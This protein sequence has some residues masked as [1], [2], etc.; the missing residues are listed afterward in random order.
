MRGTYSSDYPLKNFF[1]KSQ[2]FFQKP[3]DKHKMLCYTISVDRRDADQLPLKL[4]LKAAGSLADGYPFPSVP[5]GGSVCPFSPLLY[6][7]GL[8]VLPITAMVFIVMS[9]LTTGKDL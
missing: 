4:P 1:K 8:V 3:L 9:F 2:T 7:I 6:G 5:L